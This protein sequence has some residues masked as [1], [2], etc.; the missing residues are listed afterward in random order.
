MLTVVVKESICK[1]LPKFLFKTWTNIFNRTWWNNSVD[2]MSTTLSAML[3]R[4]PQLRRSQQ[5]G[6]PSKSN[7]LKN[8]KVDQI[9]SKR[10]ST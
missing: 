5:E 6:R 7:I 2:I 3:Q 8:T 9:Y 4:C 10:I 1:I